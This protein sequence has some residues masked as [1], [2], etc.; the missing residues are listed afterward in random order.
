MRAGSNHLV[1]V[2]DLC[3]SFYDTGTRI[4]ILTGVNLGL[5]TGETLAIVGPSGI[6]KSTLLHILGALERPDRGTFLFQGDD[7][8]LFQTALQ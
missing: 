4:D 7:V 1:S 5:D 2:R 3:K 6:G 8:F